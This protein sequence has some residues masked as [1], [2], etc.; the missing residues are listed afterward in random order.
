LATKSNFTK[1]ETHS[2]SGSW[3]G[4]YLRLN[5]DNLKKVVSQTFFE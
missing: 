3:D 4:N 2:L 1:A 5:K